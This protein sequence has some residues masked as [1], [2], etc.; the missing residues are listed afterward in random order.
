MP[1]S[2]IV[3]VT[4]TKE[5][6]QI[7][8]ASFGNVLIAGYHTHFTGI[9]E[10]EAAT[11]LADM[12]LDGFLTSDPIYKT[13][14][15]LLSASPKIS[16][17]KIGA[18][19]TAWAQTLK[20]VPVALNLGVY[21]GTFKALPWTFTADSSATVAE[22]CTGIAAAINGLAGAPTT[23]VASAT[24]V[25]CTAVT[26][27]KAYDFSPPTG[28][29][30]YTIEDI[31]PDA[32]LAADLAAFRAADTDWYGLLLDSPSRVRNVIAATWA[33]T[34]QVVFAASSAD[35][36]FDV[37]GCSGA[38]K[39]L[40]F[41]RSGVWY[42][43]NAT[44]PL[45]AGIMGA[46]FPYNPGAATWKFKTIAGVS[47]PSPAQQSAS[48]KAALKANNANY[49]YTVAG[50]G[51]TSEGVTASGEFYDITQGIDFVHARTGEAVFGVL[52]AAP[53]LPYTDESGDRFR[54]AI[55]GV[56]KLAAT[57][58]YNIIAKDPKP[59]ITI[60]LVKDQSP[61]DRAARL[62]AGMGFN[63]QLAGGIHATQINA[64]VSV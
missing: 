6:A 7:L 53:K 24:D 58:D 11:A 13:A 9:R 4:I 15:V 30:Q 57:S 29:G 52:K 25:T 3:N 43:P 45:G 44:E 49:Y 5:S 33:E 40:S 21:S 8:R 1:L 55:D 35:F 34:D 50:V 23:A 10:Y 14:N 26:S 39:A 38:M 41:A 37:A 56:L 47:I 22:V 17:F 36:K 60:P 16:K 64:T 32:G 59:L 51:I 31:T 12:L 61:S 62:F 54:S 63:A 20:I 46:V 2:D 28:T 42:H 27:E 48:T 19:S 18:T